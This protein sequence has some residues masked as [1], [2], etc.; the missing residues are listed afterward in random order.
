[1]SDKTTQAHDC[2]TCDICAGHRLRDE[3]AKRADHWS[4]NSPMFFGWVVMDAFL[5]GCKHGR[6][7]P[8]EESNR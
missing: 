6:N 7:H 1:M 4:G 8:I 3:L 2:D 5:A